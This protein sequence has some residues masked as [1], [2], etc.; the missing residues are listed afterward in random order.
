MSADSTTQLAESTGKIPFVVGHDTFFTWF[1]VVGHLSTSGHQPIIALHGGPGLVH[2]YLLPLADLA[3]SSI[4][5]IFYDQ[6]GNGSAHRNR[7]RMWLTRNLRQSSHAANKPA[8]FWSIDLM[9]DELVNLLRYFGIEQGFSLFGHSVSSLLA[10][11]C[12]TTSSTDLFQW[13]GVLASEFA[14]RRRPSGLKHI[15]LTSS[16]ASAEAYKNSA[17]ELVSSFP[18]WVRE[19]MGTPMKDPRY[20]KA[21][22]AFFAKH[23][24]R[25]NPQPPDFWYSLDQ[26]IEHDHIRAGMCVPFAPKSIARSPANGAPSRFDHKH[27]EL[28]NWTIVDRLHEIEVPTLVINGKYDVCQDSVVKPFFER[29]PRVKWVRFEKSSHTPFFEE[30]EE[31]M[32]LVAGFV[33][34]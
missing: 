34:Y 26:G 17:R 24:C 28:P 15:I 33:H 32:S 12:R 7:T 31:F 5:V 6:L 8:E 21:F 20:R 3:K 2:N 4:P 29:I 10:A 18:E 11:H 1:K 22:E 25:L 16:L 9:I 13:G 23:G 19:G 30:R 27:G 14:V